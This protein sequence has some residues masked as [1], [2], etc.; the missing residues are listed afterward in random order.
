MWGQDVGI[1]SKI[2]QTCTKEIC[3]SVWEIIANAIAIA[4]GAEVVWIFIALALYNVHHKEGKSHTPTQAASAG[5]I[6]PPYPMLVLP[7]RL[8]DFWLGHPSCSLR[9]SFFSQREFF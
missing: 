7:S 4:L 3:R 9:V 8:F 1:V 5:R 2:V 6:S